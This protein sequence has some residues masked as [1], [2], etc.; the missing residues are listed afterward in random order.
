LVDAPGTAR[1]H[2]EAPE[3]DGVIRVPRDLKV[4]SWVQT[5]IVEAE[6]PD[7]VGVPVAA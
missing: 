7:L 5:R 3:I 2:R 4:G 6:G 1:S